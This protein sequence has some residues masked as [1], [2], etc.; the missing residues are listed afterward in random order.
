MMQ[1][2]LDPR[3]K[4]KTGHFSCQ[5]KCTRMFG[6]CIAYG[7]LDARTTATEMS[8]NDDTHPP[9]ESALLVGLE[10]CVQ[11]LQGP[12]DERR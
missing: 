6:L 1:S 12:S 2:K 3:L 5:G 10:E 8:I 7:L 11:L 9:S 4:K